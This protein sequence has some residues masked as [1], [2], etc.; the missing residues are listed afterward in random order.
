MVI[1]GMK[2]EDWE[3]DL[4]FLEISERAKARILPGWFID[5]DWDKKR[6]RAEDKGGGKDKTKDSEI[7]IDRRQLSR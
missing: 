5:L 6:V 2:M 4:G 3:L 7:Y 1:S